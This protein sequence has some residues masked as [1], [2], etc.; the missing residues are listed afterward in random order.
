[1]KESLQTFPFEAYELSSYLKKRD[2]TQHRNEFQLELQN[3]ELDY[4]KN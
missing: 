2:H 4:N 3:A 1:M